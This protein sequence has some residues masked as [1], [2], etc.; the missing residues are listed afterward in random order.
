MSFIPSEYQEKI[1][2]FIKN[3]SGNAVINAKAGSGKTSTIVESIHLIPQKEKVLFVAFNK[4]I[5]QELS[6]RLQSYSNAM[7]RTYHSLGYSILR[8]NFS[9][10]NISVNEH[11]Y[12]SYLHNNIC[13]LSSICNELNKSD[14]RTYKSNIR[15]LLDYARYNL[16]QSENELLRLCDKYGLTLVGD[17]CKVVLSLL[18]WGCNHISEIDYTDMIWICNELNL[19]TKRYKF[20]FIFI[21]EAQDS[22]IMQQNL[23]KKCYRR[24]TRFIAIGDKL[25][26]I[27][28]FAGADNEAFSKFQ[29]EPNTI[30]L[31]LPITYRCPKKIVDYVNSVCEVDI[32][33]APNAIDGAIRFNVNPYEPKD[34]DMV[35][36]RN[37]AHLVKLYM[38]YNRVN[39]KSY[40]KGRN[41]GDMLKTLITQTNKDMISS[42]MLYDGV[43]P[44]LYEHLFLTINKEI[45]IT[46]LEYEEIV[47]SSK[48]M[49]LIDAIK[50][51]EVLSEGLKYTTQ[52]LCKINTIFTDDNKEGIC[53]STIHKS[54]GLES[55]NVF[56]LCDSLLPSKYARKQWEIIAEEN[57]RYVA[58]TR[59]KKTLNYISEKDFPANLFGENGDILTELEVQRHKMNRAINSNIQQFINER[60]SK[61]E[62]ISNDAQA[63]LTKNTNK[64]KQSTSKRKKNVGGKKFSKLLK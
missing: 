42:D 51:I 63:I 23:I 22:S 61:E 62:Q 32:Q 49:D 40:L 47:N 48:I 28:A 45:D 26:C 21:D 1:F 8:E 33:P 19:E 36:C 43:V 54:K 16:A 50:A 2:D 31:D 4:A 9:G 25:Q 29:K 53:L 17:E 12:T 27:N 37:S 13:N 59:A 6:K 38:K 41:I 34:N 35:L 39:K 30:T 15:S 57:L 5:E 24:G 10:Y 60:I 56:I 14:F 46:G 11:K 7:I 64:V 18:A 58:I 52:L 44:R 20:D 55:D 3:G